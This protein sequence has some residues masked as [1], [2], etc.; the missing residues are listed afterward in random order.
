LEPTG[1]NGTSKLDIRERPDGDVYVEG[2]SEIIVKSREEVARILDQGNTKRST[3]AHK[4][5]LG[6]L[7]GCAE[8]LSFCDC[9]LHA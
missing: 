8:Y 6:L 3:A 1:K 9:A 4:W 7:K 2:A 5:V